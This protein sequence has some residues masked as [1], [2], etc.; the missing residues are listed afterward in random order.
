ML[1]LGRNTENESEVKS[2]KRETATLESV[3]EGNKP[4]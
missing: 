2:A 3:D 4:S 1:L